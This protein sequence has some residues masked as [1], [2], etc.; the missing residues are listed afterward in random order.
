MSFSVFHTMVLSDVMTGLLKSLAFATIIVHVGCLEG[1][2]VEGGTGRSRPRRDFGSRQVHFSGDPCRRG[3]HSNLL[4]DGRTLKAVDRGPEAT[5]SGP[6]ISVRDVGRRATTAAAYSTESTWISRVE[7]RWS[8]WA[9]ERVREEYPPAPDH[10]FGTPT[11]RPDPHQRSRSGQ[12]QIQGKL[13]K[14]RRSIGS[15]FR[16]LRYSIQC[17]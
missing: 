5:W 4:P 16:T 8:Y 15:R 1:F 7:K 17:R 6:A 14:L 9:A 13:K 12:P 11:V 2:R 3:I 10:R